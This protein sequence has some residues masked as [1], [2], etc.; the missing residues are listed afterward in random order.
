MA[1]S[2]QRMR[3]LPGPVGLGTERQHMLMASFLP[4]L[5]PPL[6]LDNPSLTPISPSLCLK[7]VDA[8]VVDCKVK[9]SKSSNPKNC[10]QF[11]I[12]SAFSSPRRDTHFH[13][14]LSLC[15]WR[16]EQSVPRCASCACPG[17]S[18]L[19]LKP[20]QLLL[21]SSALNSLL[22]SKSPGRVS[23]ATQKL[24]EQNAP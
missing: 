6:C 3:G 23:C 9:R 1:A 11:L 8:P 21:F 20:F 14:S 12:Y 5:P 17:D 7:L 15:H 18:A 24:R 16:T 4:P 22:S 19:F 13:S 10:L 2:V